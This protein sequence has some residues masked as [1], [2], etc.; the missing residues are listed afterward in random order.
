ATLVTE[1]LEYRIHLL[2]PDRDRGSRDGEPVQARKLDLRP[3]LQLDLEDQVLIL[4]VFDVID[5]ALGDGREPFRLQRLLVCLLDEAIEGFLV[6]RW[7]E[8][9]LH[10]ASGK[11][12]LPEPREAHSLRHL[13]DDATP[14]P[15]YPLG[16]YGD[17][18]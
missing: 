1:T 16:G 11:L 9:L 15:T 17:G 8:A 12:A 13:F 14:G 18:Q 5:P 6:D 4:F 10:H 7:A 2:L 3:N